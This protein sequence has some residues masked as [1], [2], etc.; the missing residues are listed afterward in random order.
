MLNRKIQ[1]EIQTAKS[2]NIIEPEKNNLSNGVP[3]YV[4]NAGEQELVKVDFIFPVGS[5]NHKNPLTAEITNSMIDEGTK[6]LTSV[7][8]AREID[9]YGAYLNLKSGKH[10][11]SLTLYTLNKYFEQTL[12]VL[13]QIIRSPIFP[14]KEFNTIIKHEFQHFMIE[15]QKTETLASEKYIQKIFG[16][17]NPYG[18]IIK[19][20]NFKELTPDILRKFH[21]KN[22]T[23]NNMKIILSGKNRLINLELLQKY[24]GSKFVTSPKIDSNNFGY[25][26]EQVNDTFFV[27]KRGALQTSIR[28]GKRIFNK[29]HPDFIKLNITNVILGGYFGSRLMS[30]IREDK[31]YTYGI[32]SSTVSFLKSGYFIIATETGKDVYKKAIKE[33]R[34]EIKILRTELI[35]DTELLHVKNYLTGNLERNF[36]GAFALSNALKSLLVFN[37]KYDYFYKFFDTVKKITPEEIRETAEKYLNEDTMLTVVA[38]SK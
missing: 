36:D 26:D 19:E 18:N 11:A 24:F 1:P 10:T 15:R 31:G 37:L 4:I 12:K 35:N 23:F 3:V 34:K 7:Q 17:N 29:L 9:Y 32:Y 27:E 28:I 22:Y 38:G 21:K 20:E 30:N 2:I 5:V 25:F 16:E 6:E 13:S 8:I 14:I 33:V